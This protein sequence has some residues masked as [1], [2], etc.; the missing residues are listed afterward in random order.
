MSSTQFQ[1]CYPTSLSV[2]ERIIK[3]ETG[4]FSQQ[5]NQT[6][7]RFSHNLADHPLFEIP[8]LVELAEFVSTHLGPEKVTCL[9]GGQVPVGCKWSDRVHKGRVEEAIAHIEESGSLVLINDAEVDPEYCALLEQIILELETLTGVPL[10]QEITWMDAY[11]FIT[12]PNTITNYHIDHESNFLFQIKGEKEVNLF[13]QKDRSILT[14]EELEA[15]YVGNVEAADYHPEH[16]SKASVYHLTPGE[17]VHHPVNAPHWVK[18]KQQFSVTLSINF[19][20]RSFDLK[21]RIYQANY[22]L[23]KLKLKPTPPGQSVWQ[24]TLKIQ[25]IGLFSTQKP[26]TKQDVHKSGINQ[27]KKLLGLPV[28]AVRK[29][30]QFPETLLLNAPVISDY[31]RFYWCFPRKTAACRGVYSTFAEALQA[32]PANARISHNQPDMHEQ[33][34]VSEYTACR[35]LG[36]LDPF[37]YPMLPWLRQAL[38]DSTTV[39]DLGGNVGVSYYGFQNHITFPENLCWTVCELSELVNA[40]EKLARETNSSA[41]K[42][43][44]ELV[45]ADGY[46]ILL[47]IGTLQYIEPTLATLLSQFKTKPRHLLINHT[48]F[49]EGPTFVTLQNLGYAFSPY[50]VENRLSFIQALQSVGYELIDSCQLDRQCRIPFHANRQVTAYYGFYFKLIEIH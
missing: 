17:G 12:S 32:L 8:R 43:T 16:Q 41:L 50:K 2:P 33:A 31:Y 27:I 14:E 19:Y 15:F 30:Q 6:S 18:T 21:A 38:E 5:F 3:A 10:R 42:F 11:I 22:F 49:Y 29:L 39:F 7:F 47:T 36:R 48:P 9:V 34:S 25:L 24:D 46:D 40:G 45:D 44:T 4:S 20:L 35:V 23:R 13:D 1:P 37:D 28:R 26:I